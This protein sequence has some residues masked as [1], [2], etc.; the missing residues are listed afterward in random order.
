M[1]VPE[2]SSNLLTT[3]IKEAQDAN[4]LAETLPDESA[5]ADLFRGGEIKTVQDLFK[6]VPTIDRTFLLQRKIGWI[7]DFYAGYS[8]ENRDLVTSTYNSLVAV[9][10]SS[11]S[12][13]EL[14]LNVQEHPE[15]DSLLQQIIMM[16][17]IMKG[18]I[19]GHL[20]TMKRA[21]ERYDDSIAKSSFGP[22]KSGVVMEPSAISYQRW[23]KIPKMAMPCSKQVTKTFNKAGFTKTF[24][25]TEYS[26]CMVE[27]AT[28][29]YPKLQIPYIRL[30]L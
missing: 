23:T 3:Y 9:A 28:A 16:K 15:N 12:A 19:Q 6:F 20:Y 7:V 24:S 26:K 22:G 1:S 21:L 30:A 10:D 13:I 2:T 5:S 29:Y 17:W 4:E 14:E 18:E 8:A 11:S 27:G 25:F